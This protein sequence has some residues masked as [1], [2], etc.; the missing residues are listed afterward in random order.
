MKNH[1][2][3]IVCPECN[4]TF[5]IDESNYALIAEQ[6]RNKEFNEELEKKV[7]NEVSQSKKLLESELKEKY[8]K[9]LSDKNKYITQLRNDM[10]LQE[11]QYK[12]KNKELEDSKDK[13]ILI[14]NSRINMNDAATKIKVQDIAKLKDEEI[15]EKDNKILELENQIKTQDD[16]KKIFQ[17]ETKEKYS[18]RI[19]LLEEELERVK[20][21]HA[22]GSKEI[23]ENLEQ[24]CLNE[25]RCVQQEA[26]RN[27][28][29]KKDNKIVNG[30]KGDYIFRDFDEDGDEITSIMFDMKNESEASNNKSKLTDKIFEKID[31]DRTNKNCE[32]A[33]VISNRE[34]D[35]P[36]YNKGIVQIFG[37]YEKLYVC[38]PQ[39]FLLLISW[40]KYI[41]T[42]KLKDK[43][44]LE[45]AR[46]NNLNQAVLSDNM[47]IFRN[48]CEEQIKGA[49]DNNKLGIQYIDEIVKKLLTVRELIVESNNHLDMAGSRVE[50]FNLENMS[51]SKKLIETTHTSE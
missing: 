11:E 8:T 24:Y 17:L 5:S 10:N 18:G 42:R 4:S 27:A 45:I 12:N 22:T 20:N 46:Q 38:R 30:T 37:K 6:V 15:F 26:Y 9:E 16:K 21:F 1:H 39:F 28:E 31:K 19:A 50:K 36:F 44:E 48:F 34:K 40:L 14:L 33:V 2:N 47:N 29:F 43:R 41:S 49:F 35:N 25:F 3:Q 51:K 32:Y 7:K 13:E 23:G